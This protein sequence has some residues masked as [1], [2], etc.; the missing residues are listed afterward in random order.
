MKRNIRILITLLLLL[1]TVIC[2]ASCSQSLYE[3]RGEEGYTVGIRFDA[4]GGR[5]K[6][7]EGVSIVEL[8]DPASGDDGEDGMKEIKI[9]AP[10]DPRR[11]DGL[12]KPDRTNYFLAG[13]YTERHE[14]TN[15]DG[16]VSYTYSGKWD[17]ETDTVKV[18]PNKEYDPEEPV[19]TLYAAWIPYFT[20]EFYSVDESGK[21]TAIG[22]SSYINLTLPAWDEST[23]R[24]DYNNFVTQSGKTFEAAYLDAAMTQPISGTINAESDYVDLEKGIA[25]TDTIR[26]YSTWMDGEWFKI[27]TAKQ[28][29]DNSSPD[30]NYI[31]CADLDFTG[32]TWDQLLATRTFN[33]KIRTEGDQVFKLSNI[34]VKQRSTGNSTTRGL[35]GALG[36]T[37]DIRNISFENVTY[38]INLSYKLNLDTFFGLLAGQADPN[39]S[40]INVSIDGQLHFAEKLMLND[41]GT[42]T[43]GKLFGLGEIEGID[44]S[45]ITFTVD[46]ESNVT[47]TEEVID[48]APTGYLILSVENN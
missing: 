12:L 48:G 18:D 45:D 14:V 10:D 2:L 44:P 7:R 35:F 24:M 16:T 8:F 23:G 5:L 29:A 13:W 3:Q 20:Y 39:T 4:G 32:V 38:E 30:G 26:I 31:I 25:T 37:A 40:L 1:G 42:Y 34:T 27:H 41:P 11:G 6:G 33:G 28:F 21:A 46:G 22:S 43:V 17:F 47:V 15:A 9:L 36:A 19:M